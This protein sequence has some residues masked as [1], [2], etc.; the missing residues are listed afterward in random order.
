[1]RRAS[2]RCALSRLEPEGGLGPELMSALGVQNGG[3]FDQTG[4]PLPRKAKAPVPP[5]TVPLLVGRYAAYG[6]ESRESDPVSTAALSR[7]VWQ[8]RKA[9]RLYGRVRPFKTG[10]NPCSLGGCRLFRLV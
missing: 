10:R 8:V 5:V 7:L 2:K 6:M 9:R 1:M 4:N 3:R